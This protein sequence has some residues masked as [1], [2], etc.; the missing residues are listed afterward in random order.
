MC[1]CV[2]GGGGR[3]STTGSTGEKLRW[4]AKGFYDVYYR[5]ER[6]GMRALPAVELQP[7]GQRLFLLALQTL[8]GGERGRAID[9]A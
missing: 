8:L 1:V 2:G 7:L 4:K 3:H 5:N 6:R 9:D